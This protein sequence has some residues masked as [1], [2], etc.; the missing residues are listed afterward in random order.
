MKFSIITAVYNGEAYIEQCIQSVL[1]QNYH[2]YEHIIV[3][4]GSTDRTV[5]IIKQYEGKYNMRWISEPDN[6]MYDAICKG[7]E[8]AQGDVFSWLNYDDM[9]FPY[10]LEIINSVMSKYSVNWCTGFPVVFSSTGIIHSMPKTIPV[11]FRRF[12]KRGYYGSV[13]M[14]VQQESTFWTKKLWDQAQGAQIRTYKMAGDYALWTLFGQYDDLYVLDM[15]VAGFRRHPGQK[16]GDIKKYRAEM[17]KI[18]WVKKLCGKFVNH[19]SYMAA[20][21]EVRVI[22]TKSIIEELEL[23]HEQSE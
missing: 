23:R 17:G 22:K 2:D 14:G 21:R 18:S 12:M 6:G 20:I 10:T 5:E 16:S 15:P 8:M 7:F 13:S 4:G 1:A 9:Y 3:D 19:L 11:Y